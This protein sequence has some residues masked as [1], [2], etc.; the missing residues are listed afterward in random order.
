[1]LLSEAERSEVRWLWPGYIPL[2]KLVMVD[3]DPGVGKSTLI[4]DIV[5][6]LTTG[7]EMPDGSRS[8]T[9]GPA[10]VVML[11]G[12]EDAGDSIL[13]RM[14]AAGGDSRRVRLRVS[15][16]RE[17]SDQS[18][19]IEDADHIADDIARSQ[20]RAVVIDPFSEFLV[21]GQSTISDPEIREALRPLRRLAQE[22]GA[23][24]IV[25]RHLRK[26][27]NKRMVHAGAG[28]M[29]IIGA[30]R[31]A[32]L[33]DRNPANPSERLM[34]VTKNSYGPEGAS[35]RYRIAG[36]RGAV[37][38][39]WLGPSEVR[40]HELEDGGGAPRTA[41]PKDDAAEW[42][43]ARLAEGP[44]ATTALQEAATGDGFAWP[45]V[46]RAAERLCVVRQKAGFQG[47]WE[48]SLPGED[49]HEPAKMI[50]SGV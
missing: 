12:E 31:A 7:R 34:V 25:V 14:E 42:I 33:C 43:A 47:G 32:L 19:T 16:R 18:P 4:G 45:T 40:A 50:M 20:A 38:V 10:G 13:P 15:V 46:R 26:G 30:A 6:R 1:M 28:S 24:V 3:G 21:S 17:Y 9:D 44:V 23:T 36:E 27:A 29:G 48:W 2:G 35:Q 41:K 22:T 39:E 8:E 5:A 11:A 37:R 49:D